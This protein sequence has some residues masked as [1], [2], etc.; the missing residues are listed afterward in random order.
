MKL[1]KNWYYYVRMHKCSGT[2]APRKPEEGRFD[3]NAKKKKRDEIKNSLQK[4]KPVEV[5]APHT[6]YTYDV[7]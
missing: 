7:L 3:R 4:Q 2:M 1:F 5:R 6:T